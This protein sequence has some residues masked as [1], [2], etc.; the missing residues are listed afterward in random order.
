MN[1]LDELSIVLFQHE[2]TAIKRSH[3]LKKNF[4]FKVT[5]E[6]KMGEKNLLR[7][8]CVLS[9]VLRTTLISN[10]TKFSLRQLK[11]YLTF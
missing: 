3:W 6:E 5:D 8:S 7:K 4:F 11:A 1:N 9:T 10:G 2:K